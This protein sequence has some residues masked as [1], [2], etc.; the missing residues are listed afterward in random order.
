MTDTESV[1]ISWY[2]APLWDLRPD[3]TSRQNSLKFEVTLRLTVSQ[4]VRLGIEHLCGTSRRNSSKFEVTL[5][6]TVSQSVC[7][8]IEHP[9]VGIARSSKLLYDWQSVSQ[10]V[11][12]SWHRAP[13]WHLRPDITSCRNVAVWNLRSCFCGAP[14]LTRGRVCKFPVQSLNG[15]DPLPTS[16]HLTPPHIYILSLTPVKRVNILA[17]HPLNREPVLTNGNKIQH[18]I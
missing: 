11:S 1:S 18:P 7:L 3:I 10:S 15:S 17:Y 4:S 2:R 9:P 12:M 6:L 5:R 8:G 13:L 14:S 16:P